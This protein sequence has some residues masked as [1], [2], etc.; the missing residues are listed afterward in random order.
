MVA[1][2]KQGNQEVVELLLEAKAKVTAR[3][4]KDETPLI[5]ACENKG[6]G[7]IVS[8]LLERKAS[9][10]DVCSA[11]KTALSKVAAIGD[12]EMFELLLPHCKEAKILDLQEKTGECALHHAAAG[13]LGHSLIVRSLLECK[14]NPEVANQQGDT[15]MI[16]AA[17]N[18][19]VDNIKLLILWG[20]ANADHKNKL[21]LTALRVAHV[22]DHKEAYKLL[23]NETT[24]EEDPTLAGLSADGRGSAGFVG[25]FGT[26]GVGKPPAVQQQ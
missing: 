11:G 12:T 24:V 10:T 1:G 5:A 18:G 13:G 3:N 20:H 2:C 14:A 15:P 7:G 6:A 26:G 25:Q 17:S 22:K 21:G 4:G 23:K 9:V 19:R 8:A 16:V